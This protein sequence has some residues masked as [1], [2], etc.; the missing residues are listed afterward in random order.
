MLRVYLQDQL[1]ADEA[2]RAVAGWG[3]DLGVVYFDEDTYG[4]VMVLRSVWD[5]SAEADEFLDA[6]VTYAARRYGHPANELAGGLSC[7]YGDDVLC[8][9]GLGNE[10]TV[11]LGP[12]ASTVDAVLGAVFE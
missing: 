10:V 3:G 7:W 8:L 6:Y 5:T 4:L 12:D 1:G 11:V 2:A 9:S